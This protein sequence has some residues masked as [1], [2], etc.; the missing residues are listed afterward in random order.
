MHGAGEDMAIWAMEK[1]Q[2]GE[3]QWRVCSDAAVFIGR[4]FEQQ[5]VQTVGIFSHMI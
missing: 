1:R 3:E 2:T 5:E 4:L